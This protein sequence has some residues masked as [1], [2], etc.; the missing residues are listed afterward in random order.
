V[1]IIHSQAWPGK[2]DKENCELEV[3]NRG[4]KSIMNRA[5]IWKRFFGNKGWVNHN[6]LNIPEG[7]VVYIRFLD[8]EPDHSFTLHNDLITDDYIIF[9]ADQPNEYT[10]LLEDI[11]GI[12]MMNRKH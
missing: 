4:R 5:D 8:Q 1:N 12:H 7:T 3:R 6:R 11:V 2:D 9:G 10:F